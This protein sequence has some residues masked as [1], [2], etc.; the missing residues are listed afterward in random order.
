[1]QQKV[2]VGALA[3]IGGIIIGMV[4]TLPH[5][6]LPYF[7]GLLFA[8]AALLFMVS[9]NRKSVLPFIVTLGIIAGWMN[10]SWKM[11]TR[12]P[13]HIIHYTDDRQ[14]ID[15]TEVGGRIIKEPEIR[16]FKTNVIIAPDYVKPEGSAEKIPISRGYV[17]L[18]LRPSMIRTYDSYEYG[19]YVVTHY[20]SLTQPA[21]ANNPGVFD[22]Q[23]FLRNNG[24]YGMMSIGKDYQLEKITAKKS[25]NP[26]FDIALGLKTDLLWNIKKTM[27]YPESAFLGGIMLGLRQGLSRETQDDFRAAGVA[28]VLAVSGLHVT[29]ITALLFGLLTM[30]KVPRKAIAIPVILAL[31]IFAI[32][33]GG[34]PSTLRAVIMNS[35]ALISFCYFASNLRT[36][37][38]FGIAIAASVI[39]FFSPL[40][41]FEASFL[42]SFTAVLALALLTGPLLRFFN[43]YLTSLHSIFFTIF[44]L[45]CLGSYIAYGWSFITSP[46]L[47]VEIFAILT[48]VAYLF[49]NFLPASIRFSNMPYWLISFTSAQMAIQLGLG[50]LNAF[51][52]QKYSLAAPLANFLA[53]PLIGVNVQLGIIAGILGFVPVIGDQLALIMNAANWLGVK[54]FLSSATFFADAIPYPD[55]TPP[56]LWFMLVYFVGLLLIAYHEPLSEKVRLL[57]VRWK[58]YLIEPGIQRR[59]YV[60]TGLLVLA[61]ITTFSGY[62]LEQR[63][64]ATITIFDL[65][66]FGMGGGSSQLIEL[67]TGEAIIIDGGVSTVLMR[68]KSIDWN[69]G[70]MVLSRV[71]RHKRIKSVS[72]VI[73]TSPEAEC[74]GG[75]P[76]ILEGFEI[77]EV[78]DTVPLPEVEGSLVYDYDT[79]LQVLQDSYYQ[80]KADQDFVKINYENY[81]QL[82][83]TIEANRLKRKV[84]KRGDMLVDTEWKGKKLK[85][86]VL[87][88]PQERQD[89]FRA[90]TNHS[91]VLRLEYG[92]FSCLF[93]ANVSIDGEK[94]LVTL[95]EDLDSDVLIA[96]FHAY[97]GSLYSQFLDA[98][99]PDDVIIQTVP[100]K[101]K[102][103]EI[104]TT[105]KRYKEKNCRVF[106]TDKQ[107]AVIIST[108][109]TKKYSI[110]TM[111]H[112][113][114]EER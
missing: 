53:I 113:H 33:T 109:G 13:E 55:V 36:S 16:E 114:N 74:T 46:P 69:M 44:C 57:K 77:G 100:N 87:H 3:F 68:G 67:P 111:L 30:F 19:D 54:L 49:R 98:V 22:Y 82:I 89:M 50:P 31:I 45:I 25:Q 10:V 39:L 71:L 1:M 108:D 26:L 23:K 29:I 21:P 47:W 93:P 7:G 73:L 24:I 92:D 107:G 66:V 90:T 27:P 11:D 86:H 91:L 101:W 110:K 104:D 103:K 99:S 15:K 79:F 112:H 62:T 85:L 14:Y 48:V 81:A 52:F 18:Q 41:L 83:M 97:K 56:P 20:T 43:R 72:Q 63:A 32:I 51:Y 94:T 6:A 12:S 59:V 80:K 95:A 38:L 34:R 76:A 2:M 61:A 96:P 84:V 60:A 4:W 9:K 64:T 35:I 5:E 78:I 37:L 102:K 8:S 88:P 106:R 42:Y 58:P 28:H 65:S 40:I 75:L 70:S 17:L 105:E